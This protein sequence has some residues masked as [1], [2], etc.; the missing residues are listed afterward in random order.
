MGA[1]ARVDGS[2][3]FS[4]PAFMLPRSSC[5]SLALLFVTVP[6]LPLRAQDELQELVPNNSVQGDEF[7]VAVSADGPFAVVRSQEGAFIFEQAGADWVQRQELV[8]PELETTANLGT[9]VA[10]LQGLAAVGT[11]LGEQGGMITGTVHLFEESAGTW[12]YGTELAP[13]GFGNARLFG[14]SLDFDESGGPRRLLVGDP[15]WAET[16][17]PLG[18][19]YLFEEGPG[20]WSQTDQF[21]ATDGSGGDWYGTSVAVHGDLVAIGARLDDQILSNSGSVYL[22]SK[23]PSGDYQLEQK[24]VAPEQE[25]FGEF[26]RAI[27]M[28][29]EWLVVSELRAEPTGLETG[30]LH[31]YRRSADEW[32]P[33]QQLIAKEVSENDGFGISLDL[34][35][36]RLAVGSCYKDTAG[37][38]EGAAYM[39]ENRGGVWYQI[40][41]VSRDQGQSGDLFG[42][43]VALTGDSLLCGTLKDYGSGVGVPGTL[44]RFDASESTPCEA[45]TYDLG[46][47]FAN[48]LDWFTGELLAGPVVLAITSSD[49]EAI[50]DVTLLGVS[51]AAGQ[52]PLL[53]FDVLIDF[54]TVTVV[55]MASFSGFALTAVNL[56][57]A[58]GLDAVHLQAFTY[59]TANQTWKSSPG[60]RISLCP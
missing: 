41:R 19:A 36:D 25:D 55:P 4:T 37:I 39:F 14:Y 22:Y 34:D 43:S 16:F 18:G 7:G 27:E 51:A 13:S 58:M 52:F 54:A 32:V 29:D 44:H 2:R 45:Y 33:T 26:G 17:F 50:G 11:P 46:E 60:L 31:L 30:I 5:A 12:T 40:S 56:P 1:A 10:L 24:L 21:N 48:P 15:L 35:G 42:W 59:S 23:S 6:A 20:G 49:L 8:L 47:A 28:N 9:S 38:D 3:L 53:G 57:P